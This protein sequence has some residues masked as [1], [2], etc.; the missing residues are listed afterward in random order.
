MHPLIATSA[1]LL[2]AAG[3]LAQPAAAQSTVGPRVLPM[4][5]P[6]HLRL[7]PPAASV[8]A[9]CRRYAGAFAGQFPQGPYV[10]LI[11]ASVTADPQGCVFRG[12]YAWSGDAANPQPGTTAIGPTEFLNGVMS[13]ADLRLGNLSNAGLVLHPNLHAEFYMQGSLVSRAVLTPLP[14]TSLQ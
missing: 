10:N 6:L 3:M 5:K 14:A 2:L 9:A 7:T 4:V 8:P 1:A 12:T 13:A 11:I